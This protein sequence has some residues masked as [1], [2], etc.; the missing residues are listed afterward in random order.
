MES[1]LR[2]PDKIRNFGW[3]A[4]WRSLAE[5]GFGS[6]E[7]FALFV[8][9]FCKQKAIRGALAKEENF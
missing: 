5:P 9:K 3:R 4:G 8:K 2:S 1:N 6:G 7:V